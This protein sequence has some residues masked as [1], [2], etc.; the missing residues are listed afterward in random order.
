[1]TFKNRQD[2]E[3]KASRAQAAELLDRVLEI[4][5]AHG[6]ARAKV[7]M[8][9]KLDGLTYHMRLMPAP[10]SGGAARKEKKNS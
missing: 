3:D 8:P 2:T 6:E 4:I 10:Q 7:D 5:N 9:P 1:M